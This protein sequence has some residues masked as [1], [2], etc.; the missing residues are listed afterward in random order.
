MAVRI[1]PNQASPNAVGTSRTIK[2]APIDVDNTP[3]T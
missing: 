1:G 3:A 2:Q